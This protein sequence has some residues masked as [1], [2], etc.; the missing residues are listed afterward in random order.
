MSVAVFML[1]F[2]VRNSGCSLDRLVG[3]MKAVATVYE[4]EVAEDLEFARSVFYVVQAETSKCIRV[5]AKIV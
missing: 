4:M 5:C 3:E 2:A 1:I